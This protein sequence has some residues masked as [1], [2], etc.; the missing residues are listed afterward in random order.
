MGIF[1]SLKG[2]RWGYLGELGG[3]LNNQAPLNLLPQESHL[4]GNP[5][6]EVKRAARESL[7]RVMVLGLVF[8]VYRFLFMFTGLTRLV[9]L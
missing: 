6:R 8:S 3:L 2:T 5:T 7:T 9:G 4:K 1:G